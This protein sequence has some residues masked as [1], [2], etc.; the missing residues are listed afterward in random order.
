[1]F[2]RDDVV[3]FLVGKWHKVAGYCWQ[4]GCWSVYAPLYQA[5]DYG[6][7]SHLNDEWVCVYVHGHL[8]AMRPS[9]IE[10]VHVRVTIA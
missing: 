2:Q 6:R 10:L 5:G 8:V 4:H 3:I 9:D 7:V 1:M